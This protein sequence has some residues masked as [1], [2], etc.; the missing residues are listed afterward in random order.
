MR[1]YVCIH[2]INL[3]CVPLYYVHDPEKHMQQTCVKLLKLYCTSALYNYSLT[4]S[5]LLRIHTDT[6]YVL[7]VH[8]TCA[9]FPLPHSACMGMQSDV[10]IPYIVP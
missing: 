3:A 9:Q 8:K 4:W 7:K 6:I 1:M 5:H 10:G 2:N